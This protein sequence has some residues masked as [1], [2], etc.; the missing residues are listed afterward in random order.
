MYGS[1]STSCC[2]PNVTFCVELEQFRSLDHINADIGI[3]VSPRAT[4]LREIYLEDLN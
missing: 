3:L 2:L 4:A 1:V